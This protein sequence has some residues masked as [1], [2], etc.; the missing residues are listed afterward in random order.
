MDLYPVAGD[1]R[2]R[3]LLSLLQQLAIIQAVLLSLVFLLRVDVVGFA[4]AL[5]AG[6]AFGIGF[7]RMYVPKRLK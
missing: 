3:A 6:L 2:K 1:T 5:V 7:V 4:L